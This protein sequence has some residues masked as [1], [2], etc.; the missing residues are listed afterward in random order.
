MLFKFLSL[1]VLAII[2]FSGGPFVISS[3]NDIRPTGIIWKPTEHSLKLMAMSVALSSFLL[4]FWTFDMK[5]KSKLRFIITKV[6]GNYPHK[7][8]LILVN[9]KDKNE[10]IIHVNMVPKRFGDSLCIFSM[11]DEPLALPSF[12]HYGIMFETTDNLL[13]TNHNCNFYLYAILGNGKKVKCKPVKNYWDW[14]T[15]SG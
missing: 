6:P 1:G 2:I 9:E 12:G 13:R 8:R 7:R 5:S 15:Y 14:G 3:L 4:S 11:K 10:V